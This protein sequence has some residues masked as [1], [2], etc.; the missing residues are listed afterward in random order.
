MT[1]ETIRKSIPFE[2]ILGLIPKFVEA[3][4][5]STTVK[6]GAIWKQVLSENGYDPE[7]AS[8]IYDNYIDKK[9]PQYTSAIKEAQSSPKEQKP[10]VTREFDGPKDPIDEVFD[11]RYRNRHNGDRLNY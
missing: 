2:E 3:R 8:Y 6:E 5:R 4:R 1:I 9:D 11:Q 10:K 7:L